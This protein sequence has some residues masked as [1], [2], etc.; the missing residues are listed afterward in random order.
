VNGWRYMIAFVTLAW[1][2]LVIFNGGSRAYADAWLDGTPRFHEDAVSLAQTLGHSDRT[3]LAPALAGALPPAAYEVGD[4]REFYATDMSNGSQYSL[5]ASCRAVSDKAYIFVENGRPAASEKMES[6]LLAFDGI[7]DTI[8]GHFGLP[9]DSVDGDPRI[10]ILLMDII[11]GERVDGT[12]IMGYFDPI[13]QYQNSQ[14]P[15]WA[16]WIR[17]VS[18]EVEMFYVDYAVLDLK[19]DGAE[20]LVAHEFTH[21]VQ[22]ARDPEEAIWIDEGIAV[23]AEAM[24]GYEVDHLISAF[25]DE[26]DTPLLN[27]YDSLAD[28]GAAYLFFA[29]VSERYGGIP[30]IASIVKNEDHGTASIEQSLAAQ[31]ESVSFSDLFSDWV[32]ANYLDDPDLGDGAYGYA[33]FDVHLKPSVVEAL[34]PIDSKVSIIEPWSAHY[35]EFTKGQDDA[36]SLTVSNNSS[37][38]DIVAQVMEY[39]GGIRV[40]SFK[41]GEAASG[42]SLIS[43]ESQ[44]A[45]LVIASQ[46]DPPESG[47]RFS[48]Y[49][50]SAEIHSVIS[51]V[52]PRISMKITKWGTIK[53]D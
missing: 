47:R 41:S 44:R 11:D 14:L 30:A 33:A 32:I 12:R 35:I 43:P 51:F 20:D 45:I 27:W 6:L 18:N 5:T 9:P 26:P 49:A 39:D 53:G 37:R 3:M 1:V 7:Y 29:Y 22:W 2:G 10:Y 19:P 4:E 31:G 42:S 36:I 24:L 15:R 28:Y 17:Q 13:N 38:A 25:E 48:S 50:Y 21:L 23:Y 52:V 34:Y 46:P 40:S 16:R 8:T